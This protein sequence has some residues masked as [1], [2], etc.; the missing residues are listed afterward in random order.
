[1]WKVPS[2]VFEVGVKVA[3]VGESKTIRFIAELDRNIYC[4]S[5]IHVDIKSCAGTVPVPKQ[6]VAG[7]NQ[8]EQRR[9]QRTSVSGHFEVIRGS[10]YDR[11]DKNND[12]D[13]NA[14]QGSCAHRRRLFGKILLPR[15]ANLNAITQSSV[16]W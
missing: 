11:A 5:A 15:N 6:M 14:G 16:H 2:G 7:Q 1:M 3:C 10:Y 4:L 12:R 8:L 9:R 13:R